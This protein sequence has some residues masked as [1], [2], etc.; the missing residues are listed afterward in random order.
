LGDQGPIA[1][2]FLRLAEI[3]DVQGNADRAWQ[4]Y[5][6]SAGIYAQLAEAAKAQGHS[7]IAQRL[8]ERSRKIREKLI[9]DRGAEPHS[10]DREQ[11]EP[12]PTIEEGATTPF[13]KMFREAV[14]LHTRDPNQ[15]VFRMEQD[16]FYDHPNEEGFLVQ[17]SFALGGWADQQYGVAAGMQV[18]THQ[19]GIPYFFAFKDPPQN[20]WVPVQDNKGNPLPLAVYV[21]GV[22]GVYGKWLYPQRP[23][24]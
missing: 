10:H 21:D 9:V 13:Q 12:Q 6:T 23:P 15:D 2:S 1:T 11:A 16:G 17:S 24:D 22:M 3:A 18:R 19:G 7:D 8:D 20:T 4:L 5:E 14:R